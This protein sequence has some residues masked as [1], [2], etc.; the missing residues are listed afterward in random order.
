MIYYIIFHLVCGLIAA[1]ILCA[2]VQAKFSLPECYREDAGMSLFVG[3]MGGPVSLFAAFFITGFAEY[4]C[5]L[6]KRS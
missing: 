6:R 1:G 4:G 2:Y 3:F 5:S